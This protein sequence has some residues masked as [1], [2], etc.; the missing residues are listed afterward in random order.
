MQINVTKSRC[1]RFGARSNCN[2]ADLTLQDG[3]RVDLADSCRYLGV[4]LVSAQSFRYSSHEA[5]AS[6]YRSFNGIFG[7]V[8]RY[9][10]EDVVLSLVTSKCLSVLLYATE[11]CLLLS[12]DLSL[13]SFALTGVLKKIFLFSLK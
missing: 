10:S 7:K 8:G 12:R 5:R 13:N 3:D 4:Y 9:A 6:F 1:L 2:C 11:V